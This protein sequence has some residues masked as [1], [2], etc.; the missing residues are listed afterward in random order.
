MW[1]FILGVVA[2]LGL[3]LVIRT[4]L[5]Q[6]E[7]DESWNSSTAGLELGPNRRLALR[8]MRL[9]LR[10]HLRV[11]DKQVAP[12]YRALA[13]QVSLTEEEEWEAKLRNP[14][15]MASA[16]AE[17]IEMVTRCANEADPLV[18]EIDAMLAKHGS[19]LPPAAATL[20]SPTDARKASTP[21]PPNGLGGRFEALQRRGAQFGVQFS[22]ATGS[23]E[24]NQVEYAGAFV[25]GFIEGSAHVAGFSYDQ[26][27][28]S[29]KLRYEL[30]AF[31]IADAVCQYLDLP[32]EVPASLAWTRIASG[33]AFQ[34]SFDAD[35]VGRALGERHA[36]V[37]AVY[38][39]AMTA[40]SP[41]GIRLGEIGRA[42]MR[43]LLNGSDAELRAIGADVIAFATK[44]V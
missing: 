43:S 10:Q 40:G 37:V 38:N 7:V 18:Q 2:A 33:D 9:G 1:M 29:V 35:S 14:G 12:L 13:V 31:G 36:L 34:E 19:P 39:R 24:M 22:P 30:A 42:T 3:Y 4:T 20:S 41:A 16:L 23:S 44:N 27:S 32:F 8:M 5:A 25:A 26:A 11:P 21:A 17:F 28:P 15:A 6:R